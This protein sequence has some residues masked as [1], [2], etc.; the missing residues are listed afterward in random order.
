MRGPIPTLRVSNTKIRNNRQG[1]LASYYN[2][3]L[4]ELGDHYLR[5]ANESIQ[6]VN[7]EISHNDAEA[8]HIHS[9]FWNVYNSNISEIAIHVNNR[10]MT[11][12]FIFFFLH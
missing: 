1:V 6:F 4:D 2:R 8:I 9:P 11:F 12:I 10:Y 3:Y 5:K 7:C